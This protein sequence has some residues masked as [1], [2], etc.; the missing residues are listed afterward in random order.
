M[1]E[2]K[3]P[4]PNA[5]KD[6]HYTADQ[7]TV[8]EGL[9][10]VR[11]RP[12]MYI[13]DTHLRGL[14]HCVFEIVDNAIDEALAGFCTTI[15]VIIHVDN[16]ITV[17]DDGRGI[18]VDIHPVEK[19]SAAE[20]VYT[21][22]HAGGKFNQAGSAYKVSGGLH[23]VGASV[24]NA[25]SKWLRLSIKKNGKLHKIVF[26]NGKALGPLQEVGPLEDPQ[27]TGTSVTF[28]PNNEI[29][30]V[31]EFSFDVLA[32]RSLEMA[33]LNK[34]LKI[35]LED[36]RNDKKEEFCYKGGIAEFVTYLN[37]GKTPLHKTP[38][39]FTSSRDDYEVE[40]GMQWTDS[41]NEVLSG[42][43]NN[44]AT[45]EGGTHISGF[46]TALSKVINKYG[47]DNNLLKNTS[48]TGDDVREGLTAIVSVKLAE[49]QFEGQTKSKLGNSEI[50]GIVSSLVGE[51]LKQ[52]FEENP[53]VARIVIRK[54][55][56]AAAA[57][58]AARRAKELTRRKTA[59]E[60]G[61]L[62]GKM[63]DCQIKD[64]TQCE[65]YIVEG[66]SAG[67]SAKQGRDR[68][69]QAV[70]PLKGKIL[71]VE[72][73]RYDKM[74]AN[75]EIKMLIQ[76]M[77]T[78]IGK[79]NFDLSKLR[80]HKIIIMTDAD[81]DGAH[82][83]T[84]MLTL[85]YRQFPELVENGHIYIAQPPLYKYKKGRVE[86]YLKD[87][88]E[89]E[90]FLISNSFQG[91]KIFVDNEELPYEKAKFLVNKFRNYT[92]DLDSYD[93]HFDHTLLKKIVQDEKINRETIKNRA[94][95]AKE[96]AALQEYFAAQE[97]LTL[98]KYDFE[99]LD[100]VKHEANMIKVTVQ[101]TARTKHFKLNAYFL[102][103]PDFA[104]LVNSFDGVKKYVNGKFKLVKTSE[105]KS[106]APQQ[107]QEQDQDQ[108]ATPSSSLAKSKVGTSKEFNGLEEFAKFVIEDG[109][110]GAYIQ[111]YKGLGEMNPEQLWETTMNPQNRALLQVEIEDTIEADQ[112]FSILMGDLVA[113][114]REFVENNALNVR[115]LDI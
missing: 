75:A 39:Y 10:A 9:E 62:P 12:G 66:D 97:S 102:E 14:H 27:E 115:N 50:E 43:A 34:G 70:L 57:R 91:Y 16:S 7:I 42:Y 63:A 86:K 100:D 20:L 33:F 48:L 5:A 17:I 56:D 30:E 104:G 69:N 22:L 58:E 46:K 18:P 110:A 61:G 4:S 95:L 71:N 54:S 23:G 112:I 88:K 103:S 40:L 19:I 83:R 114:R 73:A 82:I 52:Y 93:I 6:S 85:F 78:G 36:E 106:E 60:W 24:V 32:K 2:Q 77:G 8:L 47:Q 109:K 25:L 26:E 44:I 21:K 59:L 89:L 81:V 29:F 37:R 53:E 87:D 64:P 92:R 13:G 28:K 105:D 94:Q 76:A 41:Y 107:N 108:D 84:L 101:T 65:L 49:P 31:H 11:R 99:I 35:T 55:V 98:K 15:K 67:G 111:R 68:S 90:S 38:I 51:R 3:S 74:L 72:K 80:Y 45:P 1:E 79:D 113:P 96:V